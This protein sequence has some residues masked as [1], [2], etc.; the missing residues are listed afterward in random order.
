MT[1]MIFDPPSGWKYGFPKK[2][3][4]DILENK[5]IDKWLVDCGYPESMLELAR[6]ASRMW[7]EDE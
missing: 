3:P 1:V 4:K 5:Q 6:M 7:E 2:I